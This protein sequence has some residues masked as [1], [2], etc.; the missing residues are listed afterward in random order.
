[1]NYSNIPTPAVIDKIHLKVSDFRIK[2]CTGWG[3]SIKIAAGT[4]DVSETWYLNE[5]GFTIEKKNDKQGYPTVFVQYNPNKAAGTIESLCR[6]SGVV[7][8]TLG[9]QVLRVDVARD[10]VLQLG[11]HAYHPVIQAAARGRTKIRTYCSTITT[12]DRSGQIQLYD[13]STESRLTTAGV[14][15]LEVRYLKPKSIRGHGINTLQDLYKSDVMFLYRAAG[16][17]YLPKLL[18]L[19]V[20]VESIGRG[21]ALLKNL[22]RVGNSRPV[23]TWL[24]STGILQLGV[25][26]ALQMIQAADLPKRKAYLARQ[27]VLKYSSTVGSGMG[28]LTNEILLYFAA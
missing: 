17:L 16:Q 10:K 8:D 1:M 4:G 6:Q 15:R 2:D 24:C 5:P 13:K 19:G 18:Q 23:T 11:V 7:C 27:Q 25:D 21:A 20:D 26:A 28:S 9:G 3:K 22:Y 14:G 12:G